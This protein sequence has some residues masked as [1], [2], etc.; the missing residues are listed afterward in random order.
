MW[1]RRRRR[2]RPGRRTASG[3]HLF[4]ACPSVPY[5]KRLCPWHAL[6][7]TPTMASPGPLCQV[8]R[9]WRSPTPHPMCW[10]V[11]RKIGGRAMDGCRGV[12]VWRPGQVTGPTVHN[13]VTPLPRSGSRSD[14][15]CSGRIAG[16]TL[17]LWR[18]RT[19]NSR[20]AG[21]PA[22][23]RST[24]STSR[25]RGGRRPPPVQ[26]HPDGDVLASEAATVLEPNP[27]GRAL[28]GFHC[29]T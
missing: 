20:Q 14:E 27:G 5:A 12:G 10:Q 8:L 23:P 17:S 3:D 18:W 29:A 9:L 24:T 16:P 2:R 21:M 26:P 6:L 7:K 1:R 15:P 11:N 22:K 25:R 4:V 19:G 13:L 28:S